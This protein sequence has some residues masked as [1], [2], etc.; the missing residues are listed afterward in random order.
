M[1]LFKTESQMDLFDV[2]PQLDLFVTELKRFVTSLAPSALTQHG[3]GPCNYV[4]VNSSLPDAKL[5]DGELPD[6]KLPDG[7]KD[8]R[9][10]MMTVMMLMMSLKW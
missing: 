8:R 6:G 10:M 3:R 4:D 7:N 5:P 2:R 1:D 9:M